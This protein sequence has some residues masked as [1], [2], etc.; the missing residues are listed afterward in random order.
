MRYSAVIWEFEIIGE[1]V[2]KL[3]E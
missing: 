2:G 1:A 3:S